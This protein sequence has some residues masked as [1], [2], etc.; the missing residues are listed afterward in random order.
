M[1]SK[2]KHFL[3]EFDFVWSIPLAFLGFI[4]FPI[5]GAQIFGDGFAFYPPEFFH[6]GV[7][8][9]LITIMFNS[10]VQMGIFFNF[11]VVYDYYLGEGFKELQTWQKAAIFLFIYV[12]F[13]AS[14][15]IVWG[16]IV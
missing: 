5:L 9:G 12:F 1:I 6:A 13:Y 16:T 15:L 4:L 3:F 7:Y 11:P 8:S 14:L 10:M 2:I